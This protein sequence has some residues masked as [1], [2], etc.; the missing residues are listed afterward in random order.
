MS[1]SFRP[2]RSSALCVAGTG[3][4][5]MTEGSTPATAM[6]RMRTLGFK[7]SSLARSSL[8]INTAEAPTLSGLEFP[9]VIEPPSGMNT[10][11]KAPRASTLVSRRTH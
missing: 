4:M 2:A 10:G 8:M 11:F 5:P 7:P 6:E 9:A 3:P 1:S